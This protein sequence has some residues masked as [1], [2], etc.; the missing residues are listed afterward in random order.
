MNTFENVNL[1]C[2]PFHISKYATGKV[3]GGKTQG[4]WGTELTEVAQL[5]PGAKPQLGFGGEAPRN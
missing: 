1:K 3:V 2:T 5:G 4:V